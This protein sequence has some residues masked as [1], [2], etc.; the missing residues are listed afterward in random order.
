M[1]RRSSVVDCALLGTLWRITGWGIA[2][3]AKALELLRSLKTAPPVISH[4]LA[5]ANRLLVL[6]QMV[7]PP[8][9]CTSAAARTAAGLPHRAEPPRARALQDWFI[10]VISAKAITAGTPNIYSNWCACAC[11]TALPA[12]QCCACCCG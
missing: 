12:V 6:P 3:V 4:F 5:W 9:V 2:A 11:G 1:S 10:D 7:R 8:C